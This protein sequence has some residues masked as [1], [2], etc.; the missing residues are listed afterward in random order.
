MCLDEATEV[1]AARSAM[2]VSDAL[3]SFADEQW[4]RAWKDQAVHQCF[5]AFEAGDDAQFGVLL[6]RELRRLMAE[7]DA[8]IADRTERELNRSAA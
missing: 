5:A 4:M 7:E 1:A 6:A 8:R 2:S 3:E